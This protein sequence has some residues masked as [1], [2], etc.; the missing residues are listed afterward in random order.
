MIF[1][2]SELSDKLEDYDFEDEIVELR[3]ISSFIKAKR[4]R[5][6]SS[7]K[8]LVQKILKDIDSTHGVKINYEWLE[9]FPSN[10]NKS[11]KVF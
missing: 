11:L 1:S 9:Y 3:D 2:E 10:E 5:K 6:P 8:K 4:S 7:V